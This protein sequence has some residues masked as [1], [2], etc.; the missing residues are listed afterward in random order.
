MKAG[1]Y[2]FTTIFLIL[3]S[4]GALSAYGPSQT[5]VIGEERTQSEKKT[6]TENIRGIQA[7]TAEGEY[8]FVP[9]AT[10][11]ALS[12]SNRAQGWRVR[13][14]QDGLRLTPISGDWTWGLSLVSYGYEGT[15]Q[16]LEITEN[17]PKI[18]QDKER[19]T[20]QWDDTFVEKWRNAPNSLE[21][22]FLLKAR[23]SGQTDNQPLQIDIA[24]HG[25]LTPLLTNS[26]IIFQN[27][28][29]EKVL[30]YARPI[31]VDSANKKIVPEMVIHHLP[32]III[33]LSVN[34]SNATYPLT[35]KPLN[36]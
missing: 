31:V 10:T 20:Y 36:N 23:P 28:G 19:L 1:Q 34:D 7:V 5:G 21:Q 2:L 3:V 9:I 6:T 14:G 30:T 32:N 16:R 13:L 4:F 33:R 24:I 25:N 35:I 18:E 17:R 29:G 12:A 27:K 22:S 8:H 15:I 11:S 26:E